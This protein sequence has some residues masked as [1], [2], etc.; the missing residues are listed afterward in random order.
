MG[1]KASLVMLWAGAAGFPPA[2][3]PEAEL[4][5][6]FTSEKFHVSSSTS[7]CKDFWVLQCRRQSTVGNLALHPP[8]PPDLHPRGR[9]K[10]RSPAPAAHFSSGM[11][12]H[13]VCPHV[14]N[15]CCSRVKQGVER[16]QPEDSP[17]QQAS[18]A[19]CQSQSST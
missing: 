14:C 18:S 13:A 3:G 6:L 19:C 5:F 8:P 12:W 7:L 2:L 4:G 9:A 10:L 16:L 11:S 17:S 15:S 1:G